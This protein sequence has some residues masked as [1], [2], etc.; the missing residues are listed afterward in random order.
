MR[1]AGEPEEFVVPVVEERL[2][3]GKREIETGRVR[4]RTVVDEHA[5]TV[6]EALVHGHVEID[7]V[8][9]GEEVAQVPPVRDEGDTIVV[10]VVREEIVVTKRLILVEE[11]RLR[12]VATTETF[13]QQ[14]PVRSQRAVIERLPPENMPSENTLEVTKEN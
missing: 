12:R 2:V 8:A 13:V 14:V 4:V 9:I 1:T 10:P 11:V 6:R 7:R 5:T 3:T